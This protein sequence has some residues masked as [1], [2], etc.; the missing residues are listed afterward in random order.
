ML[1]HGGDISPLV[2]CFV[3]DRSVLFES[4]EAMVR[5]SCR[6]PFFLFLSFLLIP[7]SSPACH[8]T[9]MLGLG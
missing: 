2:V 5:E 6:L 9:M 4:R 8:P 3:R 7:L 1:K